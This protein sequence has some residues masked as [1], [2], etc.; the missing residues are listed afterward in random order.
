[1]ETTLTSM[2]TSHENTFSKIAENLT[3]LEVKQLETLNKLRKM[4]G[5]QT[6]SS[7]GEHKYL[8]SIGK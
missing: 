5:K 1:M 3:K 2:L 8:K 4:N 7:F 6:V